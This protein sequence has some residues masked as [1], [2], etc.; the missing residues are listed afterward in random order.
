M[1]VRDFQL[2]IRGKVLMGI[3]AATPLN[4]ETSFG[5]SIHV[6]RGQTG[7]NEEI[8]MSKEYNQG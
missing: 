2:Q 5:T 8:L 1:W 7:P 4:F 6:F 3:L